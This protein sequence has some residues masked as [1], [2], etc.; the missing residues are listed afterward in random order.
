VTWNT[1][2]TWDNLGH[3]AD[4]LGV[5]TALPLLAAAAYFWSR[6]QR[7][8]RR[9]RHLAGVTSER[10]VALVVSLAGTRICP[11]VEAFCTGFAQPML[12]YE[13]QRSGDLT[14]AEFPRVLFE[15]QTLKNRLI[16]EGVSEVH[17][18]L[19]C[20]LAVACAVGALLDNWVPVKVYQFNQGLYEFWTTLHGGYVADIGNG[21]NDA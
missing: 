21:G 1:F 19:S 8:R 2:F 5:V 11:A 6:A 20:P 16:D 4:T 13:V 9:L 10:P 14:Q 18:F 12:L 3:L 15:L 17:L 7:Y